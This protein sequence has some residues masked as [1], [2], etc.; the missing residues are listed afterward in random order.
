MFAPAQAPAVA[1]ARHTPGTGAWL[2]L[3]PLIAWLA[4]FVAVPGL[5]LVVISFCARDEIGRIVF[6]FT[7]ENY[8]RAFD[9]AYLR[10][11]SVSLWQAFL[12]ALVCVVAGYPVAWCIGRA[13]KRMRGVLLLLVIIPFWI[14]FL[15]RTYA[16]ISIL[17]TE[18]LF[19]GA[20]LATHLSGEPVSLLYSK[21]AVVLGL[22]YNYLPFAILPIYGSVEKLDRSLMEA[23][24]DLGARPAQIFARVILPLTWPGIVAGFLLVFVPAIAMFAIATLMGGGAVPTIGNVIQNQ[25]TAARNAP[26]GAALGTLLML[27][28]FCTTWV[29]LLLQ[30]RFAIRNSP[31]SSLCAASEKA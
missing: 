14:S 9:P 31:A 16:W 23:A 22:I 19:N 17:S 6:R 28:F 12:S 20:L 27:L 3:S 13:S 2:L 21:F 5:M 25:F 24:C 8:A 30:S 7:L 11:L 18:G 15:V 1:H 4:L 29:L 26:F 10:I